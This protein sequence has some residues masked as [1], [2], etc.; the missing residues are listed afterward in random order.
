MKTKLMS[1][2]LALGMIVTV[3]AGCGSSAAS[4]A[5]PADSSPAAE[6]TAE[7]AEEPEAV[8]EAAPA[9]EAAPEEAA[10]VDEAKDPTAVGDSAVEEAL[11]EIEIPDLELPLSEE[12]ITLTYWQQKPGGAVSSVAPN[13]YFDYPHFQE[14]ARQTGVTLD[15]IQAEFMTANEQFNLMVASQDYPDIF[16]N[17]NSLYSAGDDNGIEEE[18]ILALEDYEDLFPHYQKYRTSTKFLE[19]ATSTSEGHI[20]GFYELMSDFIGPFFGMMGRGDWIEELGMDMPETYDELHELLLAMQDKYGCTTTIYLD[21]AAV[22]NDNFLA[23][24]YGIACMLATNA[25]ESYWMVQDGVVTDGITGEGYKEYLTM[26]HQWYEEKLISSDFTNAAGAM[27]A[28]GMGEITSGNCGVFFNGAPMMSMYSANSDDPNLRI[29]GMPDPVKEKGEKT[30]VDTTEFDFGAERMSISTKCENPEIAIQYCD[31]WFTDA[32]IQLANYGVEGESCEVVD[33][34]A[35]FTD[36][37]LNNPDLAAGDAIS[38]YT[39]RNSTPSWSSNS[40]LLVSYN[41]DESAAFDTWAA[42]RD[43]R[44]AY[45]YV[46]QLTIDETYEISKLA[47]DYE[48][49][50]LECRDKFIVGDMDI[51]TEYEAYEESVREMGLTRALEIKQDAY[52]RY[53][54]Q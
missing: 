14:A 6:E 28:D 10:P 38:F 27:S 43:N 20:S 44:D 22:G 42:S 26:L 32:G 34:V 3:F 29:V 48:S 51:E 50:A 40:K 12:G 54:E 7:A 1:L 19:T 16:G 2:L 41:E 31:Y 47:A 15:F 39:G 53:M 9:E 36:L 5:A 45:P 21:S 30:H 46:A 23:A 17:F 24:G 18:I 52:D 49:Y 13:G 8:E 4:S 35:Q 37:V 11:A 25:K 33:G